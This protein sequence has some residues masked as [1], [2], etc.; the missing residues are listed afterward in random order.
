MNIIVV[1]Y[2]DFAKKLAAEIPEA[3]FIEINE[4]VFPDGEICPRILI[5]DEEL[6]QNAHVIIALQ[7]ELT[8][9]KNQYLISL[10]LTIYNI[11]R[12][13]V[14]K[15][16]CVM[17]YH[18]YSR[19][20]RETRLGE[21]LSSRYLALMLENAGIDNFLTINSHSYG[22]TPLSNFFRKTN[23]IS[24][25]AI[26]TA[27]KAVK[28]RSGATQDI[29]CFS[30]D[31]GALMLAE[32]AAN[33]INSPFFGAIKKTRDPETGEITQKLIGIDIPIQNREIL[34]VDDLVS[35]GGTMIGAAKIFKQLGAKAIYLAYIHGVHS[36]ENFLNLEKIDCQ[37]IL[38]TNTIKI[39]FPNLTVISIIGLISDW[40]KT[41]I[42][43]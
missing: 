34:I 19:Q 9:S 5:E 17:P 43:K 40:I 23:A 39:N 30:P 8:Q 15:I 41:K 33:A 13:G 25:S 32:E 20:D 26:P 36:H 14:A 42:L 16:T 29:L 4:R 6:F 3:E 11:K 1:G 31:E 7:L 12:F 35:S 2:H 27:A 38:T 21:P 18:I 10:L 37:L 28:D 24:L 22:K